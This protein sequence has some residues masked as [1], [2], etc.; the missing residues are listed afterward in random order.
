MT[1]KVSES[2]VEAKNH[3]IVQ[4]LH[5]LGNGKDIEYKTSLH[6]YRWAVG[7]GNS[8]GNQSAGELT[9]GE[10]TSFGKTN[11]F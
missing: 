10:C 4:D 2:V 11:V 1:V 9:V 8:L 5:R 3:E 6:M 7:K